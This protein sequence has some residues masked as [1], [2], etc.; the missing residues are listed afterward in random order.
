[1]DELNFKK[2]H[3]SRLTLRALLCLLGL[4]IQSC[5]APEDDNPGF[6]RLS[7][8]K[9]SLAANDFQMTAQ[10]EGADIQCAGEESVSMELAWLIKAPFQRV[11]SSAP[12]LVERSGIGF[13]VKQMADG[14]FKIVTPESEWCS[15]VCGV[16]TVVISA[17][18]S[19]DKDN[20]YSFFIKSG[21]VGSDSVALKL[22]KPE[23]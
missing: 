18:C 7:C 19:T 9:T 12:A 2:K 3:S 10:S 6:C 8:D 20:S 16:A 23:A 13:A 14:A 5:S 11:G 21:A 4:L 17:T 15:D 22:K 1:M